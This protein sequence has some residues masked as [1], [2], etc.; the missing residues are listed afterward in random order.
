[1]IMGCTSS[2]FVSA[3]TCGVKKYWGGVLSNSANLNTSDTKKRSPKRRKIVISCMW[4]SVSRKILL[5]DRVYYSC[6]SFPTRIFPS[7]LC[8]L[9]LSTPLFSVWNSLLCSALLCPSL[10]I[11][12]LLCTARLFS[13]PLFSSLLFS[14]LHC[15]SLLLSSLLFSFLLFSSLLFSSIL[16]LSSLL[17]ILLYYSFLYS[18]FSALLY[19]S[20]IYFSLLNSSLL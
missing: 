8:W 11:S 10:L 18:I 17:F 1:M 6:L 14:T 13:S 12:S 5:T 16:L 4:P 19:F 7:L 2:L 3:P 20:G 9:P 15:S